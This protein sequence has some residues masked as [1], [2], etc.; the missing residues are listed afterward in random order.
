M[1]IYGKILFSQTS[2][3]ENKNSQ[4]KAVIRTVFLIPDKR[5]WSMNG[6]IEF[7]IQHVGDPLAFDVETKA[8]GSLIGFALAYGPAL[9]ESK[10]FDVGLIK[11]N[12]SKKLMSRNFITHY[13]L[14]D[15]VVF[16]KLGIEVRI[17]YDTYSA[18]KL[19]LWQRPEGF[20]LQHLASEFL[21]MHWDS[22]EQLFEKYDTNALENVPMSKVI[23]KCRKDASATFRLSI[24]FRRMVG[25]GSRREELIRVES[26]MNHVLAHM[27]YQG[28]GFDIKYM[29]GIKKS[30]RM[31][32]L[33][34]EKRM[35][36]FVPD[37]ELHSNDTLVRQLFGKEG[38]HIDSRGMPI[39]PKTGR[40]SVRGDIFDWYSD[41]HPILGL[42]SSW[43]K[44]DKMLNTYTDSYSNEVGEDGRIHSKLDSFGAD[45]GRL[46][47]SGPNLQNIPKTTLGRVI[48]KAFVARPGYTLVD[49]DYSQIQLVILSVFSG[50]ETLMEIFR[51]GKDMHELVAAMLYDKPKSEIT[52]EERNSVKAVNFGLP[53]GGGH[54]L[55]E[56]WAGADENKQKQYRDK[57]Y[58]MF[59][60]IREY[61]SGFWSATQ[62]SRNSNETWMG[63]RRLLREL[64]EDA[65][66]SEKAGKIRLLVNGDIQ[67]T[68]GDLLKMGMVKVFDVLNSPESYLIMCVHDEVLF[69]VRD[70]VL[71]P[72]IERLVKALKSVRFPIPL[73]VNV[74]AGKNWYDLKKIRC[75]ENR[76]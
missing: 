71:K 70:D 21:G 68:E 49:V 20:S 5:R 64:G 74:E 37:I 39:T 41:R 73:Q 26:E 44:V 31:S 3:Q 32:Q 17:E 30:L 52:V 28:I 19:L 35:K 46:S 7:L 18:A 50:D 23:M 1:L 16:L 59:P 56:P 65:S 10:W 27:R 55:F 76:D 6:L 11:S 12:R 54:W 9:S 75:G 45:T 63:R 15:A 48:R 13:G 22:I 36:V 25:E 38:L 29:S 67:G 62:L 33:K 42:I 14:Y 47:S 58:E 53:F 2:I 34:L 40:V 43:K 69:E 51:S 4:R 24:H 72:T 8:D 66:L 57:W 60:G 61:L